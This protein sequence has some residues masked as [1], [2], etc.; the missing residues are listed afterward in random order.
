ME[1]ECI[2]WN[3]F[4]GNI[5]ISMCLVSGFLNQRLLE[6]TDNELNEHPR[7]VFE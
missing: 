6:T 3:S 1:G 4:F 5:T 7:R 2:F